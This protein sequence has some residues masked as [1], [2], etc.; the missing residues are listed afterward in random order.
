VGGQFWDGR[1][2]SLEDQAKAPFLNALE[3]NNPDKQAVVKKVRSSRYAPLFLAVYGLR[4]FNDVNTAYKNIAKAIA[5]FERTTA[6]K[7]FSA[8]YDAYLAGRAELSS[9][10]ALGLQLFEDPAKGNCAACHPSSPS[11]DGP[12]LFTDFSYDNIGIPKNPNNG[13]YQQTAAYNPQGAA[14]VDLGLGATVGS[15]DEDGK[16]KVPTL[17]N[18]ARTAPYMHNGY[19]SDLRSVVDFYNSR[20]VASFPEPE[21]PDTVNHDELGNLGLSASEVDAIVAFLETLDDGYF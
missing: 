9:E 14:F 15:Q 11:D 19:F 13:F 17:R 1:A 8:K 10:E 7:P 21:V 18:I 4:A 6:F 20:D 2:S 12:A 5:V 3:M 16:F